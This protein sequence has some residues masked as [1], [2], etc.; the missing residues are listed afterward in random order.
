[1]SPI[2]STSQP[3]KVKEQPHKQNQQGQLGR[4]SSSQSITYLAEPDVIESKFFS[5]SVQNFRTTTI[6]EEREEDLRLIK[7]TPPLPIALI[8]KTETE[9]PG[10]KNLIESE[11]EPEPSQPIATKPIGIIEKRNSTPKIELA[12]TAADL[13]KDFPKTNQNHHISL[14]LPETPRFIES[15]KLF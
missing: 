7:Q 14:I 12:S 1:L 5:S 3:I 13:T 6:I 9:L 4:R 2:K 15:G 8:N 10:K 11:P